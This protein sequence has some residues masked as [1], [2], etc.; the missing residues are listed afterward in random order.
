M[1]SLSLSD[2]R[3]DGR[4]DR[5]RRG[6]CWQF[7][8][9]SI[10]DV[11]HEAISDNND[12]IKWGRSRHWSWNEESKLSKGRVRGFKA[13]RAAKSFVQTRAWREWGDQEVTVHKV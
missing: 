11:V 9:P 10:S 3:A 4:P 13:T 5:Q 6:T 8:A 1:N 7:L 2:V 12:P